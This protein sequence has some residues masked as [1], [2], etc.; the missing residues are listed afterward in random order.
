MK[1]ITVN[2]WEVSSLFVVIQAKELNEYTQRNVVLKFS[3]NES[4]TGWSLSNRPQKS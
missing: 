3:K 1:P 4:L 2:G